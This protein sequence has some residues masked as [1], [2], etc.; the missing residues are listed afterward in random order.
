MFLNLIKREQLK[1]D[2][3]G[4]G[5]ALAKLS[6]PIRQVVETNSRS[7]SHLKYFTLA[8]RIILNTLTLP[9]ADELSEADERLSKMV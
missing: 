4:S 1:N 7:V 6:T 3:M 8:I 9:Q 2:Y 5:P